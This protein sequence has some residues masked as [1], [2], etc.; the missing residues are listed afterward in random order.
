MP[1]EK[2]VLFVCTGN[3]CRSPMAEGLFRKAVEGRSDYAVSSAGTS[4]S[5]GDSAAR[6]TIAALRRRESR[7]AHHRPDYPHHAAVAIRSDITLHAALAA[8]R[9][10]TPAPVLESL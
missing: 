7:G 1:A 6:E 9:D 4:A 3:T 8:A 10:L 2:H 5:S